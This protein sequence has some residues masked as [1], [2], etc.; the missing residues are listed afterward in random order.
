MLANPHSS[1]SPGERFKKSEEGPQEQLRPGAAAG[2][3]DGATSRIDAV[4]LGQD[5][6]GE[7][8]LRQQD[9]EGQYSWR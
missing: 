6:L 9:Q 4:G 2:A 5:D 7:L 3:G 8:Q 1:Q